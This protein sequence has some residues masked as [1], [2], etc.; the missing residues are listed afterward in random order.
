MAKVPLNSVGKQAEEEQRV[1]LEKI[2]AIQRQLERLARREWIDESASRPQ[3][4]KIVYPELLELCRELKWEVQEK[5]GPSQARSCMNLCLLL[6]YCSAN[7]DRSK[8]YI[9]LCI[10]GGQS[11]NDCKNQ[12]FIC[13]AE[14]QDVFL[15]EDAYKTRPTYGTNKTDLTPLTFLTYYL[16]LYRTKMRPLLLNGKDHNFF[17]VNARGDPFTQNSYNSYISAMFEK[18]FSLKLTTVDLRKAVV[19]HF[20]S[21]PESGDASLRESFATLMKHSVRTQ[22][23]FYDER[24]LADKK[25]RALDFLSSM[26]SRNLEEDEVQIIEDEDSEGNIEISP[27]PGDFVALVAADS[28]HSSPKCFLTKLLRL[29]EDRKTAFLAEFSDIEA[30]KFKLNA[31]KCYKE[32][33]SA[34]IYPV[35]V[36]YLHS[37]GLYELRTSKLDI[38]NQVYKQ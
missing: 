19:S 26:V 11:S 25:S 28:T 33:L 30:G 29:S 10:H 2:R 27:L 35:D 13:F 24:P 15:L 18:Y 34:V 7:P 16:K 21:L 37:N 20:L 12:N 22:R 32:A 6:L 8:E 5:S 17:F 38:H 4:D 9:T 31:G 3:L 36:V 1:S 23:R 14:N